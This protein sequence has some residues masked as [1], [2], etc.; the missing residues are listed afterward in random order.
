MEHENALHNHQLIEQHLDECIGE[1]P[2][3]RLCQELAQ[4]GQRGTIRIHLGADLV[5]G[6]Y[7]Q[8]SIAIDIATRKR[9]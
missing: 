9:I 1:V 7:W 8:R 6:T 5:G 2:L 3:Q 4:L